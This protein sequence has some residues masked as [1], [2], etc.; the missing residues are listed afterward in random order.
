MEYLSPSQT[1]VSSVTLEMKGVS[2][3][4]TFVM[5]GIEEQIA[6]GLDQGVAL[7]LL[8]YACPPNLGY[9]TP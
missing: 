1:A 2:F 7:R 9:A 4:P 5:P 6:A 8:D 3:D